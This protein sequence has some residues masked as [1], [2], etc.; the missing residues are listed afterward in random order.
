MGS[1]KSHTQIRIR[2]A[3]WWRF[4]AY[5]GMKYYFFFIKNLFIIYDFLEQMRRKLFL[6]RGFCRSLIWSNGLIKSSL[7]TMARVVL[8][9][10]NTFLILMHFMAPQRSPPP[11]QYSAFS[12]IIIIEFHRGLTFTCWLRIFHSGSFS[13]SGRPLENPRQRHRTSARQTSL[14][15]WW[16]W[17]FRARR[18]AAAVP[19]LFLWAA[20]ISYEVIEFYRHCSRALSC[21]CHPLSTGFPSLDAVIICGFPLEWVPLTQG[22]QAINSV[23]QFV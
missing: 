10:F 23:Q 13:C 12:D 5:A 19:S 14:G 21:S 6:V 11:S 3:G 2:I 4:A 9:H 22:G 17:L 18:V 20:L 8:E 1:N 15:K 7:K 16:E